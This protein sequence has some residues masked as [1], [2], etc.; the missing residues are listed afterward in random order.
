MSSKDCAPFNNF[1]KNYGEK[2]STENV[3]FEPENILC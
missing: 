1:I 2:H 3:R